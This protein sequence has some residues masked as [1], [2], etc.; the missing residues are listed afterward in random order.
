MYFCDYKYT[1]ENT[2]NYVVM[3]KVHHLC[4]IRLQHVADGKDSCAYPRHV[5]N[6][7]MYMAARAVR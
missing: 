7:H 5:F 2:V 4:T 6:C 3:N 1:D